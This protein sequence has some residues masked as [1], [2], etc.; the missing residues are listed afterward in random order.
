MAG[1]GGLLFLDVMLAKGARDGL[2]V[3]SGL[4]TTK[5]FDS[6]VRLAYELAKKTRA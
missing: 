1:R 6:E 4:E 5:H 2:R 3:A